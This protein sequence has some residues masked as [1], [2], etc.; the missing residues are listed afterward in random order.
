[1]SE[2]YKHASLIKWYQ[3]SFIKLVPAMQ[4]QCRLT[5]EW[6][7]QQLRAKNKDF[8]FNRASLS[9]IVWIGAG[10]NVIKLFTV[11]IYESS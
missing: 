10:A 5:D 11:V 3:Q 9:S 8:F 1:M 6:Q 4:I 7:N 2:K